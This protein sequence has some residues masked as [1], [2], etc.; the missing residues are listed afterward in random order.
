MRQNAA[1]CDNGLTAQS[2]VLTNVTEKGPEHNIGK[3]EKSSSK[4]G[5]SP[6]PKFLFHHLKYKLIHLRHF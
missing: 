6:F 2:L 5:L 1:S 3:E 4:P